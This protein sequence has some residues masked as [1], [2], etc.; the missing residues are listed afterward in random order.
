MTETESNLQERYKLAKERILELKEGNDANQIYKEYLKQCGQLFENIADI[1]EKVSTKRL[2]TCSLEQL[3]GYCEFFYSPIR[4]N[5]AKSYA[6]PV[7]AVQNFGRED[8]SYLCYFFTHFR[9]AISYAYQGRLPLI[10]RRMELFLQLYRELLDERALKS[11]LYYEIHDYS[12]VEVGEAMDELLDPSLSCFVDLVMESDFDDERYL[13]LY[14]EPITENEIFMARH[15]RS[16]TREQLDAMART[17]TEGYRNGFLAAGIDLSRKKTVDIRYRIG[18]EPMV[19]QAIHQFQEMGLE[20]II[21]CKSNVRQQGVTSTPANKQ[22]IYDH[23]FDDSLYLNRA[24]MKQKLQETRRCYERRR[25]LAYGYAGPAVIEIFGEQLFMPEKKKESPSYSKEQELLSIAFRRD[26]MLIR[27]EFI[28]GDKYSFT[29]IS[30]PIPEIGKD[31]GEIFNRTVEVNTLSLSLYK[32]IQE[33][34][35]QALDK[36]EYVTVTGRNGNCTNLRVKLHKL[37]DPEKQTNFENCLADVNI[38]LGEVFTSPVLKGTEGLLHVKQVYLNELKYEH[39]K[40]E[41]TDGMISDYSCSNYE[42]ESDN[43]KYI[44][45]NI[46]HNRDTLPMGEFAIGTNTTA[47]RMGQDFNIQDKLPILIAEKTGPHFAVGDTCYSMSEDV[48]VRNPDGKE[49]IAKDNE[50]SILRKTDIEKAYFNCH[51]DITV[52]YG[53]LGDIV[54]HTIDGNEI[55]LIQDGYFVLPGTE[56]LNKLL[57]N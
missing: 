10:V 47:Y 46:M 41:F 30:Y 8:G 26:S 16:M 34:L 38:P 7:F 17:Y 12:E 57:Q 33:Q 55:P 50:C 14:G 23:R 21:Y 29:I 37:V 1:Y 32:E 19:R 51:T 48:V 13:Y 49:V 9:D 31:F 54:V 2:Q 42:T 25:D 22:Y 45:E 36:G 20:P 28:P 44:K 35:I 56:I 4:E 24:L 3:E 5:Y 52:S 39:L 43:R 15:L 11:L 6:N 40:I 18:F 53:E 27:N